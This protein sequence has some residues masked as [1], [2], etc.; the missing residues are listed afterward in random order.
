MKNIIHK[1][2]ILIPNEK[3]DFS[4]WAV[5]ACDQYTSEEEYW[6][7]VENIVGEDASTLNIVLPEVYLDNFETSRT[8]E[9]IQKKMLEY[10][11]NILTKSIDGFVYV[12][13]TIN[14]GDIRK[15]IVACIDLEDYSYKEGEFPLIRPSE[16]TIEERIPPRL[17]VRNKASL[18]TPHIM[19]LIDDDKFEIIEPLSQIKDELV[20]CYN[21]DLMKNGGH[22]TG[23]EITQDNII[24]DLEQKFINLANVEKFKSKYKNVKNDKP[25]AMAVGDGNHS[26]AT[27]KA[28]WEKTKANLN[29]ETLKNHPARYCLVEI[30][31]VHSKSIEIEPI[32]RVVLGIAEDEFENKMEQFFKENKNILNEDIHKFSLVTKLGEK[33]ISITSPIGAIPVASVEFFLDDLCSKNKNVKLDYVHGDNTVRKLAKDGAIGIILPEFEKSDL[34]KGVVLGGVLPRKTFSMGCANEKRY[35]IECRNIEKT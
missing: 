6:H 4:K 12:E 31:N 15:G 9:K 17:K 21:F 35:Y 11:E 13:R 8:I 2:K 14:N 5:V 32:H 22:I 1:S 19:M 26:L 28:Y 16:N 10:K 33:E 30:V 18:E 20:K 23:Y 29:D 25:I 24:K 34:F 27:A 3:I 7:D